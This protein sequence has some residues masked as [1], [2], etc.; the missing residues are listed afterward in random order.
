[1]SFVRT[2]HVMGVVVDLAGTESCN[3]F[4]VNCPWG[5]HIQ[6]MRWWS[7]LVSLQVNTNLDIFG[8][9]ES[10]LSNCLNQIILWASL[11]ISL[12]NIR[13]WEGLACCERCH[14][15]LVVL[16]DIRKQAE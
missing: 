8:K 10:Q 5:I 13:M 1:M 14:V 12:I 7:A 3:V 9:R 4:G 6:R 16:G 2:W 15:G 11:G